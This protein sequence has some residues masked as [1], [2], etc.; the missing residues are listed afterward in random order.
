VIRSLG[1]VLLLS[2]LIVPVCGQ[3]VVTQE[4]EL[5]DVI[6]TSHRGHYRRKGNTAVEVMRAA[7]KTKDSIVN[8]NADEDRRF[9]T[10]TL[11]Y[12]TTLFSIR[13][14][15]NDSLVLWV[16]ADK[17]FDLGGLQDNVRKLFKPIDIYRNSID[18]LSMRLVSPMSST[19]ALS[20]YHY[21][22]LDTV[23]INGQACYDIAFV[24]FNSGSVGFS[25]HLYITQDSTFRL[26][27][28]TLYMPAAA[29]TNW[30]RKM[31]CTNSLTGKNE[32][33]I[34]LALTRKAKHSITA[35]LATAPTTAPQ[36]EADSIVPRLMEKPRL[37]SLALAYYA[38]ADD[39]L[40]TAAIRDNSKWDFGP[41]FSTVSYNQQEGARIRIGGMTTSSLSRHW[42]AS[43][44]LAYGFKDNRPKGAA[45]VLYSF[46]EHERHPY[47][48]NRHYLRLSAGYDLEELG[49]SYR[50]IER[51]NIWNSIRFDYSYQRMLYV[52]RIQLQYEKEWHNGLSL[53][54]H[55]DAANYASN[56]DW[57]GK[58]YYHDYGWT[59]ELRYTPGGHVYNNRRGRESLFNLCKDAPILRLSNEMGYIPEDKVFYDKIKLS[60]SKRFWLSGFGH[61]DADIEIGYMPAGRE[62]LTKLFYPTRNNSLI[63][64]PKAFQLIR[65][66]EFIGD[67]YVGGHFAYY[68][69][70][71]FYNLLPGIKRLRLRGIISYHLLS[72][73]NSG[74]TTHNMLPYMEMTVGIEN[75]FKFLRV[76]YVRR[77]THIEG[78]G[79]WERNGI[80]IAIKVTM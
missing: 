48:N 75:I 34:E 11:K 36:V 12:D 30:I 76:E 45:S 68:G 18:V 54:T 6:I 32:M 42:Y 63:G 71:W 15:E 58:N 19:M 55:I 50:V 46:T 14:W 8:V 70:G 52:A 65:P 13:Q 25:G 1:I 56:G 22:I 57:L 61:V 77:L 26:L 33:E 67:R 4:Y 47:Q 49:Q 53:L 38:L 62:V 23:E 64:D 44:Y 37:R 40:P 41:I 5:D 29:N 78:L 21:Y 7:I 10:L 43:A 27:Q 69:E 20:Y 16:G 28:Y 17:L 79:P 9:E 24:P 66:N 51:D 74:E 59:A 3:D 2:A 80:R 72:S 73:Y 35:N 39:Y 60:A 31:R